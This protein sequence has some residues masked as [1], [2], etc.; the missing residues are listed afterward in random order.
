M[1]DTPTEVPLDQRFRE[2]EQYS[3]DF[4]PPP[5]PQQVL[6]DY[7]KPCGKLGYC[8]CPKCNPR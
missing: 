5:Q 7:V 2:A 6:A 8:Y 1:N 3:F 4:T